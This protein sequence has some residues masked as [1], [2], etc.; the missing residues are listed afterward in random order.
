MARRWSRS[1]VCT[2]CNRRA[3]VPPEIVVAASGMRVEVGSLQEG[4]VSDFGLQLKL[5]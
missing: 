4:R 1:G 5:E 3:E 2:G